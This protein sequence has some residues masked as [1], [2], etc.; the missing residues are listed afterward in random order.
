MIFVADLFCYF[1]WSLLEIILGIGVHKLVLLQKLHWFSFFF[2]Y[3]LELVFA[4][5]SHEFVHEYMKRPEYVELMRRLGALGDGNQDQ[6]KI[7]LPV[8]SFASSLGRKQVGLRDKLL[9]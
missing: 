2:Q 9:F 5:N 8:I 3:D 4:K 6:S 7:R 1:H